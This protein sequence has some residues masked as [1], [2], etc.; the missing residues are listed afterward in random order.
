M[1]QKTKASKKFL[2]CGKFGRPWGIKG[3]VSVFWY[4]G[5][6]PVVVGK[7]EVFT[8]ETKNE[9]IPHRILKEH[10]KGT[11]GVVLLDGVHT[12]EQAASLT[13][14]KIYIPE[15]T[16][17]AL[18][19]GEYYCYQ[20]IGLKVETEQGQCLGEIIKIVPTGSNDVYEVKPAEGETFLIPAIKDVVK[21]VDVEKGVIV[22]K[23]IEGL[24]DL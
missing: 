23:L 4:S 20:L 12:P 19:E 24:L 6:C 10:K 21:K 5:I 1:R 11:R 9:Y 18:A 13:N 15:Q 3:Q 8:L 17:P 7:G 2:E 14:K 16:L 22:I